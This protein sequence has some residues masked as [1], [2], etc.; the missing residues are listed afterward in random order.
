MRLRV[1]FPY[2]ATELTPEQRARLQPHFRDVIPDPLPPYGWSGV[3]AVPDVF[4]AAP[5]VEFSV[6]GEEVEAH[7]FEV[8]LDRLTA[9]ERKLAAPPAT[10]V[11]ERCN[12]VVPGIGLLAIRQ[13]RVETD[14]CTERLQEWLDEGWQ[15]L[16]IC[17]QPDQRRPDY[18]LGRPA[19]AAGTELAR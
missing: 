17:P 14:C 6:A 4:A 1:R 2:S 16:A 18:V 13:V 7:T 8:L 12:V 10:P 9:I 11:N 19:N 5:E 15:I 3:A